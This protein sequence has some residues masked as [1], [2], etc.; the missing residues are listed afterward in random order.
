MPEA[1]T[2]PIATFDS[3][4]VHFTKATARPTATDVATSSNFEKVGDI[5][6]FP[7]MGGAPETIDVTTLTDHRKRNINGVQD[8][9]AL[10]FE[11]NYTK[12]LSTKLTGLEKKGEAEWYAL[13]I[14]ADAS[15]NHDG[16]NGVFT[17]QGGVSHYVESGKV[18]DAVKIK[19]TFSTA[20][21]VEMVAE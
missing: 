17:W 7:D 14:G 15:G 16:H 9:K 21:A 8:S 13:V 10:E 12:A 11:F 4:L 1:S 6:N 19:A 5:I 3:F 2:T 18:N 20:S